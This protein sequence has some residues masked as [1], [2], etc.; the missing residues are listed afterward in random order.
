MIMK[1]LKTL[2]LALLIVALGSYGYQPSVAAQSTTT[3]TTLSAAVSDTNT[4]TIEVTSATGFTANTTYAFIDGELMAVQAVSGTRITVLRG[5]SGTRSGTH[6]SGA[7]VHVGPFSAFRSVDPQGSC[8]PANETYLP[9][10][11]YITGLVWNCTTQF[12][13]T[14]GGTWSAVSTNVTAK[15]RV[16][17]RLITGNY[18]VV[19]SDYIIA[20][21]TYTGHITVTL[22]SATGYL[23]KQLIVTDWAGNASASRTIVIAGLIDSD[24][25][26]NISTAFGSV[27]L[28]GAVTATSG[29]VWRQW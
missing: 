9:Q 4:N 28:I 8:V 22:P 11:N 20:S 7:I 13:A 14:S 26:V 17:V 19:A 15:D 5:A 25:G 29:F 16:P 2:V 21:K 18:T 1:T 12:G 6:R 24:S 10:I 27:R 23:G 3:Q